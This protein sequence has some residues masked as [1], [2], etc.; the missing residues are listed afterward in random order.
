MS[1]KAYPSGVSGEEQA[2]VSLRGGGS[3]VA[4]SFWLLPS[5]TMSWLWAKSPSLIRSL[6]HSIHCCLKP[7]IRR[8]NAPQ[9]GQN[10]RFH[11][12]PTRAIHQAGHELFGPFQ[13]DW[14]G[15]PFFSSEHHRQ[16]S[17]FLR[18]FHV[19]YPAH[20]LMGHIAIEKEERI[21][22]LILR[23]RGAC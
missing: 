15:A 16:P 14:N 23:R 5:R 21:E 13:A 7:C 10:A 1:R 8:H 19:I 3:R 20:K 2:F 9:R 4:R 11:P 22:R 18:A 12:L 6:R 17:G